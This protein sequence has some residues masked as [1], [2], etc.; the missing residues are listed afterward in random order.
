MGF[1]KKHSMLLINVSLILVVL[2]WVMYFKGLYNE[3]KRNFSE[4]K[5]YSRWLI[6]NESD[7]SFNNIIGETFELFINWELFHKWNT[8]NSFNEKLTELLNT[9]SKKQIYVNIYNWDELVKTEIFKYSDFGYLI[10][11]KGIINNIK[12]WF[13]NSKGKTDIKLKDYLFF[14]NKLLNKKIELI[15]DSFTEN[16]N[17]EIYYSEDNKSFKVNSNKVFLSSVKDI[18]LNIAKVDENIQLRDSAIDIYLIQKENVYFEQVEKL[19]SIIKQLTKKEFTLESSLEW[20]DYNKV[21]DSIYSL[22]IGKITI[23]KEWD[24]FKISFPTWFITDYVNY[25]KELNF[26]ELDETLFDEEFW[27]FSKINLEN[28]SDEITEKP[29]LYSISHWWITENKPN[30]TNFKVLSYWNWFS[31]DY[32]WLKKELKLFINKTVSEDIDNID[33]SLNNRLF[34]S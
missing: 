34:F 27:N 20:L 21:K 29:S 15:K 19:N 4:I 2:S 1:F 3:S 26:I 14:D 17:W 16:S 23:S 12:T 28:K 22:N 32:V 18:K 9:N 25:N 10:N 6:N 5:N 8:L 24:N 31:F 33:L 11:I 13:I 30:E 7:I